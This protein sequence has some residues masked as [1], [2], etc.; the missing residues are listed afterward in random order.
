MGKKRKMRTPFPLAGLDRRGPYRQQ[1]PY[2]SPDMLNVRQDATLEGRERGGSRPGLVVS[3]REDLGTNVR[4]LHPMTLALGDSFTTFSDGFSGSSLA[5][6]W[7][8]ASWATDVPSI[9]PGDLAA[10]DTSTAEGEVVLDALTIDTSSN[11]EVEALI[12]P[13]KGEWHGSYRMYLRLDNTTPAYATDGVQIE[14]IQTGATGA[15]T[16]SLKSYT[17]G[18]ETVTDTDSG[19][20]AGPNPGWLTATVAGNVVTV[21]W[22][23]T[24]I[25]TGTV[26]A[27]TGTRVGLGMACSTTDG[28]CLCNVFRVQ[29]YST[30]TVESLRSQLIASCDGDL[31]KEGP[32]GRMTVITSDLTVRDDVPV[33]A[34]Q[35]GQKLYLADYGDLRDTGTDGTLTSGVLDD[36]GGQDWSTL[37][38]DTDSDICVLSSVGGGTTA[39]AYTISSVHATNGVTLGTDPGD[40]TAT[41]R[42]ER[43]PKIYDPLTDTISLWTATSGKGQVP[44]GCP[45]ICR[46]SNRLFLAG[47]AI[48]PQIW[49]CS[50]D[51]DVLDWDFSQTDVGSAIAGTSADVGVPGDPL[52]AMFAFSDDYLIFGCMD[53]IWRYNGDPGY[54]GKLDNLSQ[55]VGII[56][57]DAWTRGPN[58]ELVFLSLGGLFTLDP[59]GNSYPVDLSEKSLPVEFKNID[60]EQSTILLEYDV[61]DRG[62]HIYITENVSNARIHWWFDWDSKNFWP[63]TVAANYE[64]TATCSYQ[65]SAVEESGVLLGCRDGKLRRFS[66]LAGNDCGTAFTNYVIIGPIPL[67]PDDYVGTVLA[68]DA[69]LAAESSDVTWSTHPS[70]TFQGSVSATA[71][72]TGT[73][74]AGLN[75][76]EMPEASRGQAMTMKL[77]GTANGRWAF[78]SATIVVMASGRR[79]VS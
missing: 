49:Y 19:T 35:Y 71:A 4:M 5:A 43:G 26:D 69:V 27:H 3:H 60:P 65:A 50:R 79:L 9:F 22:Q 17:G 7:T 16:A 1:A 41:Y 10:V 40:G 42:I 34:A 31:Y 75:A 70:E 67:A 62:V 72:D 44:T 32:Y 46:F 55:T 78:E 30:G 47:A 38:I 57:E 24:Q 33:K 58:G 23:G 64:P 13:W 53:S 66:W 61:A 56:D 18:V 63:M 77:T 76:R 37:G 11:Y 59:G 48:A 15:Y 45:L 74:E 21:W 2:T 12:A 28:V 8:Q 54:G 36:T 51:G 39:G 52:T 6:A 25:L 20:I 73:W 29:Y 68:I 14:I